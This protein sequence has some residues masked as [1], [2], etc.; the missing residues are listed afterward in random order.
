[1]KIEIAES[2]IYSYLKHQEGC[3]LVQT[4]WR[5]SGKWILT[6]YELENAQSLYDRLSSSEL[7]SNLFKNSSFNQLIKQAE[8]DVLGLNNVENTIYGIDIAFHSSGINYGSRNETGS[9]II[10]KIFR[11]IFIMQSYFNEYEKFKSY[12]I[13]P[14]VNP[15]D[16][17]YIEHLIEEAREVIEDKNIEIEFISNEYFY[18]EI[19]DPLIKSI[20]DEHDTS[21]L[22]SRAI[23]LL[24]L[25]NRISDSKSTSRKLE[26]KKTKSQI[27]K[28]IEFGM[29]IG[30]FAQY[31]FQKAFEQ[32]LISGNEIQNLQN[33][34][35][36]KRVFNSNFEIL[37]NKNRDITDDKGR[38]RYYSKQIYCGNYHLTSQ[39]Y[40]RQWD[41]LLNW[42]KNIGYRY[43]AP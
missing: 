36:S 39:W 3:R 35:Y 33:P 7:F 8:I 22:F 41:L 27:D 32:N 16:K 42:L 23:K 5:T 28:R 14:K 20:Q 37:R 31:S 12:F 1:M 18:N 15:F 29:K 2:L 4:N 30:Q 34:D 40:D 17:E 25:D 9:R 19:V 11:T 21:E 38:T 43:N 26:I 10:K 6:E 24:S 13:T